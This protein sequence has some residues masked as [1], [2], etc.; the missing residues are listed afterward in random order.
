M[1]AVN[2]DLSLDVMAAYN[3][4]VR[5]SLIA[6]NGYECQEQEGNYMIAFARPSEALEWCLMLQEIMMEVAWSPPM[7]SLPSMHEEL[8]PLTGAVL[9]RGPRIKAGMYQGVPTKVSPHSTT[10]RADYFGPL[11]NR[12]ARYCHAAAQGGQVIVA[13]PLLEEILRELL[14]DAFVSAERLPAEELPVRAVAVVDNSGVVPPRWCMPQDVGASEGGGTGGNAGG[15]PPQRRPSPPFYSSS[16]GGGMT[17]AERG[18]ARRGS[19]GLGSGGRNSQQPGRREPLQ[20]LGGANTDGASSPG[21]VVVMSDRPISTTFAFG[22]TW[23]SDASHPLAR[24]SYQRTTPTINLGGRVE[25]ITAATAGIASAALAERELALSMPGSASS[26]SPPL[27]SE[28][29]SAAA[30]AAAEAAASAAAASAAAAITPPPGAEGVTA[31]AAGGEPGDASFPGFATV[32]VALHELAEYDIQP[33]SV[34]RRMRPAVELALQQSRRAADHHHR[35]QVHNQG[36]LGAAFAGAI[37]SSRP[38]SRKSGSIATAAAAAAVANM[39]ASPTGGVGGGR[40]SVDSPWPR[41]LTAGGSVASAAQLPLQPQ[42]LLSPSAAAAGA[43]GPGPPSGTSPGAA[44]AGTAAAAATTAAAAAMVRNLMMRGSEPAYL[45]TSPLPHGALQAELMRGYRARGLGAVRNDSLPTLVP[46]LEAAARGP[47]GTA[48]GGAAGARQRMSLDL[49]LTS[50]NHSLGGH[51][52]YHRPHHSLGHRHRR[53][54]SQAH[55]PPPLQAGAS[56]ASRHG[57]GHGHGQSYGQ[58][59]SGH[60]GHGEYGRGGQG[61]SSSAAVPRL[62]ASPTSGRPQSSGVAQSLPLGSSPFPHSY[63]PQPPQWRPSGAASASASAGTAGA[64]YA[65]AT[66]PLRSTSIRF[67]AHRMASVVPQAAPQPIPSGGAGYGHAHGHGAPSL[68]MSYPTQHPQPHYTVISH[69]PPGGAGA[70]LSSAAAPGPP[71]PLLHTQLGSGAWR[72][73]G[74]AHPSNTLQSMESMMS[75]EHSATFAALWEIATDDGGLRSGSRADCGPHSAAAGAS[76]AAPGRGS[77]DLG[78]AA[79]LRYTPDAPRLPAALRGAVERAPHRASFMMLESAPGCLPTLPELCIR[80]RVG[81]FKWLWAHELVVEDLGL[82]RFKGVAGNHA[83]VTVCTAGTS[84]RKLGSRVKKTKG[85]RVEPGKG[86]L[87]R[88]QLR[89]ADLPATLVPHESLMRT[90][91]A[92]GGAG[93][94]PGADDS[95]MLDA[96]GP[97]ASPGAGPLTPI[98]ATGAGPGAG[99]IRSAAG[100]VGLAITMP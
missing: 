2:R 85:E 80:R 97:L 69:V 98:E 5:R 74:G 87:Y 50:S 31:V 58:P 34:P 86:L 61:G 13:R 68:P 47:S 71:S 45:D 1:T 41:G 48:A 21:S 15:V 73:G 22:D 81:P 25:S 92:L 14:R 7:L 65:S 77:L 52:A 4:C 72:D 9:F 99:P 55:A 32:E 27:S 59:G 43:A 95:G 75:H 10:G 42:A 11:V 91:D 26:T 94:A 37:L 79:A 30:R 70:S 96:S 64:A 78:S 89:P 93:A 35:E 54:S 62:V 76:S 83:I 90:T 100:A 6:C 39:L 8:H 3:D 88:V 51:T 46:D 23:T 53:R 56:S 36:Q 24:P 28:T 60:P 33:A 67:S 66:P 16:G 19:S 40:R 84:E 49:G 18:H 38:G 20:L 17:A 57:H 12:A 82:F 29:T 44:A 63:H